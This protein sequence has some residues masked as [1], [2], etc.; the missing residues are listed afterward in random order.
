MCSLW[1]LCWRLNNSTKFYTTW[2]QVKSLSKVQVTVELILLYRCAKLQAEL[3]KKTREV[4]EKQTDN[5]QFWKQ[6]DQLNEEVCF[7][8]SD[9]NQIVQMNRPN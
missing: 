2:T 1:G 9:N 3:E 4:S 5:N 8:H 6:I 7:T